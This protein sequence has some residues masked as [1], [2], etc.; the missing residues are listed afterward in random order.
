MGRT[1]AALLVAGCFASAH[2]GGLAIVGT[3][4]IDNGDHDGYADTNET[5]RLWLTVKNTTAQ[6]LT[7]VT[8]HIAMSGANTACVDDADALI[9]DLPAGATLLAAE[10]LVFHVGATQDRTAL[11]KSPYDVLTATFS[12]S[13]TASSS[14]PPAVPSRL[15]FDLDLDV[16]G[17]GPATTV[18]E[19]FESGFGLFQ[20]QN[21]DFGRHT[22]NPETGTVNGYRCQYHEPYCNQASCDFSSCVM[23]GTAAAADATWWRIDGKAYTGSGSL[24]FGEALSPGPGYTT[25]VGTLEAAATIAPIHMSMEGSPVLTLKHQVS[26][27]DERAVAIPPGSTDTALDRGVVAVQLADGSGAPVGPWIKIDPSINAYD[28]VAI[29]YF[30]NCSFDPVDD[31]N[32][33]EDLYPPWTAADGINR[34][35]PSSSCAAEKVFS[36]IGST[37]G[38]FNAAAV[39]RADGP[40][41]AGSAGPGTWIE[42]SFDLS[43]FRGRSIRV[44]FLATTTA[45]GGP[46]VTWASAGFSGLGDDGW[47][48][49][50]VQIAGASATAGIVAN[51]TH[52][53]SGLTLDGDLD[54]VD[55]LCEDNCVGVANPAQTD[56][57]LDGVGDACDPCTDT[58]GD[59][60][61]NP[62]YPQSS[63]PTDNCP[64]ISNASQADG[65]TDGLGDVCDNCP[66]VANAS[67][68]NTDGDSAGDAC[69]CA[70]TNANVYP[71]GPERNDGLDNNCP[72]EA[73]YGL[74]DELS[75]TIGFFD[76][77][78]KHVLSWPAQPGATGY[79]VYSSTG[80]IN[81]NPGPAFCPSTTQSTTTFVTTNPV[82]G[83]VNFYLVGSRTPHRGAIGRTSAGVIWSNQII[84]N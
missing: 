18:T 1:L 33:E 34:R 22:T 11:G 30:S 13:F 56:T 70:P 84:C 69:D 38:A 37:D 50:D 83:R 7:G 35:G 57:D 27:L 42:T 49:D 58:D 54:G 32:R 43:R 73:D 3:E 47:W 67:Q 6:P 66:A 79:G 65:D 19:G 12:L 72:G 21:L 25:P 41:L 82:L 64:S 31:G 59:G 63:C 17:T 4:L 75:G 76:A 26:L 15:V 36:F 55:D 51:D 2:A 28:N 77:T 68:T 20:V 23:G 10:P 53:N 39:G 61:A 44:R 52:D 60:F 81:S 9:G 14:A 40:G 48:I 8:A 74:V 78:N 45:F 71:G 5:V 80:H 62:G 46:S 16:L 29:A 24:Y